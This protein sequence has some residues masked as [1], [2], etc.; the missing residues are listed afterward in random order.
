MKHV[1]LNVQEVIDKY[2]PHE[3]GMIVAER[4][5]KATAIYYLVESNNE[6]MTPEDASSF[7]EDEH[8][9]YQAT[10]LSNLESGCKEKF[11]A[12][13]RKAMRW[14]HNNDKLI[15]AWKQE[16][17]EHYCSQNKPKTKRKRK[18]KKDI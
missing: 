13:Y 7:I 15:N 9:E 18:P 3:Q 14:L 11:P 2:P 8:P 12:V 4:A 17:L 10:I 5:V 6:S 1:E 16:V